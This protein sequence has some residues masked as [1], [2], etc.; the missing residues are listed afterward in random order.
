MGGSGRSRAA[1]SRTRRGL[2]TVEAASRSRAVDRLAYSVGEAAAAL[3]I[4][5]TC[6]REHVLPALRVVYVGRRPLIPRR[7]LERYLEREARMPL[8]DEL[9][10][11][12][13]GGRCR[14]R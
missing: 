8:A 5:E 12:R 2:V 14:G 9:R 10:L 11:L 1:K 3:G 6:F 4:G 7:E 13:S